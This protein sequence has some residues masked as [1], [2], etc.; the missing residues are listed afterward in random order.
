[1]RGDLQGGCD[2]FHGDSGGPIEVTDKHGNLVQVG[3]VS[4]GMGLPGQNVHAQLYKSF[5]VRGL[6]SLCCFCLYLVRWIG[7]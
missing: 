3:L 7:R 6:D 1:M 5:G 4:F 2:A